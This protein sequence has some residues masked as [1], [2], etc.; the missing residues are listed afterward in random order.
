MLIA[1][2]MKIP[3]FSHFT[4]FF[5]RVKLV[6]LVLLVLVVVLERGENLVLRV[7]LGHLGLRYIS[8]TWDLRDAVSPALH[9]ALCSGPGLAALVTLS[10]LF[11]QGPPGRAGS[12]GNKGEMVGI[13][14]IS[15]IASLCWWGSLFGLG[16]VHQCHS[17]FI[18]VLSLQGPSGI[19]GAP[20]L[21]GGRG[22]PGPPGASGNPGAKGSPVSYWWSLHWL[23]QQI[24]W[25]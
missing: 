3:S 1:L 16:R 11:F 12:P 25:N 7:M 4:V 24:W 5:H 18:S 8:S 6:L 23:Y 22:L 2:E 19:P 10:N 20:G 21:P 14:H 17:L 15:A 13:F 9:R